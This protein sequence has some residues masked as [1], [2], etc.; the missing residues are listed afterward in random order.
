MSLQS[1][2]TRIGIDALTAPA[3]G[4]RMSANPRSTTLVWQ[5]VAG[6][7]G[8]LVEVQ[9]SYTGPQGQTWGDAYHA[10][11][12]TASVTFDFVGDQPG[13]WRITALDYTGVHGASDA[14][15]WWGFVYYARLA[16]PLLTLPAPDAQLQRIEVA[17]SWSGVTRA[18][19]YRVEVESTPDA[20]MPKAMW[21]SVYD[22]EVVGTSL[23]FQYGGDQPF[24]RW[25]VTA[26]DT[27]GAYV[28][29]APAPWRAFECL[30]VI[31]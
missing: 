3:D 21:T 8:Y 26:L 7:T 19:R 5:S 2:R 28:A 18:N 10:E 27:T 24:C 22:A 16:T 29:S 4:A 20:A 25:R 6:A 17:F 30:F 15:G 9:Y 12:P 23:S 1:W 31:A 11:V 14:T 13:R